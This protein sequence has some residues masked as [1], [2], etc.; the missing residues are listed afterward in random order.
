MQRL[1]KGRYQDNLEFLQWVYKYTQDNYAGDPENPEYNA[2]GRRNK[3]RG[4]RDYTGGNGCRHKMQR[5]SN[6]R[7]RNTRNMRPTQN[8]Q[9]T[10]SSNMSRSGN[11]NRSQQMMQEM[12]QLR[13]ENMQL[14]S[15]AI[16]VQSKADELREVAKCIEQERDY[17]FNKVL[18]VENL[19]KKYNDQNLP[20]LND[21]YAVLLKRFCIVY[22]F[23]TCF[24][25][26]L[27]VFDRFCIRMKRM[28]MEMWLMRRIMRMEIVLKI[29]ILLEMK[30]Q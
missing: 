27:Y 26:F 13:N 2:I 24:Y 4:G 8:N 1:I 9:R 29:W 28:Q 11:N 3:S 6:N 21:I 7:S 30:M 18:E 19:C 25:M 22:C 10:S 17:Y 5:R 20:L 16:D 14:K 12:K 23:Y 15:T